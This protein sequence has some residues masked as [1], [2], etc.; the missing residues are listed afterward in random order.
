MDTMLG[1]ALVV[2]I[3]GC[4]IVYV[5]APQSHGGGDL[6]KRYIALD[7]NWKGRLT[8]AFGNCLV[9]ATACVFRFLRRPSA[10]LR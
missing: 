4:V 7:R 8:R 5:I 3:I 6:F 9:Q 1:W 10:L 2:L